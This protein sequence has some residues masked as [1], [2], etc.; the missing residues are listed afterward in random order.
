MSTP[1]PI[2]ITCAGCGATPQFTAWE[3]LNVTLDPNQKDALLKG[4][5]TRFTCDECGWSGQVVHPLLYHDM[6]Q[7]FMVWLTPDGGKRDADTAR[8]PGSMPDYRFRRVADLNELRE[9]VYLFDEGLD[10][11]QMEVLKLIVELRSAQTEDRVT[12][13][14]F[15]SEQAVDDEGQP[16]IRFAHLAKGGARTLIVDARAL[17]DVAGALE[18]MLPPKSE[19]QG[20]W[21]VVD[22]AYA[23]KVMQT[24]GRE[25]GGEAPPGAPQAG[26]APPPAPQD[27]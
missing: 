2:S 10:D 15:Y 5:L 14:L 6:Q 24:V 8:F 19:E 20:A 27:S 17:V 26:S 16:V 12:G 22:R 11:R 1:S 18:E 4:E 3:S 13:P 21:M 9:K 7:Q 23:M 25:A